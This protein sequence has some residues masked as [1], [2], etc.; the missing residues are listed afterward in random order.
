M[1]K[2]TLATAL[3][4]VAF[5][6]VGGGFAIWTRMMAPVAD[7]MGH[8]MVP[9]DTSAIAGGAPIATVTLPASLSGPAQTGKQIFEVACAKCHGLN[10]AGRNGLG[11]PLIHR[12]YE[13]NHHGD[14]AFLM[15]A[16]NGVRAHHWNFGDMPPIP[17][18]SEGDVKQIA[19]YIR[20]V[21]AAN[22]IN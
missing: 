7:G 2:T 21:Q 3:A 8:S 20:E 17:G 18:L 5:L 19:R 13:P 12:F 15:A 22:G 6:V 14:Q 1:N 16:R 11:P 4:I 10:A 9:P